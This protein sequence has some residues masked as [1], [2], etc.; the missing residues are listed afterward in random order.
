MAFAKDVALLHGYFALAQQDI[1]Y[2][3]ETKESDT[4]IPGEGSL[5]TRGDSQVRA[6]TNCG[7]TG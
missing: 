7:P 3:I 5:Q 4:L 1:C 6:L 2:P